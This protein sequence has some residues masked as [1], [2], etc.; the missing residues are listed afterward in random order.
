MLYKIRPYIWPITWKLLL[1]I[2]LFQRTPFD[3]RTPWGYLAA[4]FFAVPIIYFLIR[5]SACAM[6]FPGASC[7][8][9]SAYA[10][11][12]RLSMVAINK[13]Y[14]VDKIDAKVIKSIREIIEFHAVAKQ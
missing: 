12:I 9:M 5:F 8:I 1:C 3:W 13:K 11:D 2:L 4:L 7:A 10:K 14:R 6:T